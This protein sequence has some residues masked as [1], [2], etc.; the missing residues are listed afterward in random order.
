MKNLS[1]WVGKILR[2]N[3]SDEKISCIPT[4]KFVPR[5]IGGRGVAARIYW[6]EVPPGCRAFDP[7]NK[8]IIMT[9]PATG[10]LMP[11]SARTTMT[12]KCPQTF[13]V[14]GYGRSNAGG[15]WGPELKFA[16]YDGIIIEGKAKEPVYLWINDENIEIRDA[17]KFIWGT[18]THDAQKAIWKKHGNKVKILVIGP[19]GENLSRIAVISSDSNVVFGQGGFGGVMGSKKLK[20]II[21]RGTKGLKV[22]EAQYLA[23]LNSRVEF[24]INGNKKTQNSDP[25][26]KIVAFGGWKDYGKNTK[27]YEYV[28]EGKAKWWYYS[29]FGCNICV[30]DGGAPKLGI[31]SFDESIPSCTSDCISFGFYIYPEY[32][33]YGG[34]KFGKVSVEASNLMDLLG[35]NA[36]EFNFSKKTFS[37]P[38]PRENVEG[39]DRMD[40]F[41][42]LTIM[43]YLYKDG[44]LNDDNTGIPFSKFGSK[45]FIQILLEKTAYRNGFGDILAEGLP[46]AFQYLM[47]HPK[48]FGLIEEQ[49]NAIDVRYQQGYPRAGK[50]GGYPR[51]H[52]FCGGQGCGYLYHPQILRCC[53]D[54]CDFSC[55]HV[56]TAVLRVPGVKYGS[57]EYWKIAGPLAKKWMG[58][59]KAFDQYTIDYKAEAANHGMLMAMEL[60]CLP[61]CDNKFPLWY[62]Q[63][64]E[65]K[66]GDDEIG[67]KIL[68]AITG[69]EKTQKELYEMLDPIWDLERAIAC[70][71]GRRRTDDW[72]H[73]YNFQGMD[74]EGRRLLKDDLKKLLDDLYNLRGWDLST[75]IPTKEKLESVSLI[76]VAKDL[77]RRGFYK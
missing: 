66:L 63:H 13:P 8:I 34:K 54:Q 38:D 10:S 33:Y 72:L 53:I 46:R 31:R 64:T 11:G 67:S 58:S 14:E 21:V 47:E 77:E 25:G 26:D 39:A 6:E 49:V 69:I 61:L 12:G 52:F 2:V 35:L 75:G 76:D 43:Y 65:N 19:A 37:K 68:Y 70:R 57:K 23:E 56:N 51:H 59:E 3:L 5:Y 44:I 18:N 22:A 71:E 60:D 24:L 20:A 42:G 48:E 16:G 36:Y 7:E 29:C 73:E 9:S 15:H 45:E 28:K 40:G 30:L 74:K 1:G 27:M 50:F 55:L 62:S 32:L 4:E 17:S 41:T